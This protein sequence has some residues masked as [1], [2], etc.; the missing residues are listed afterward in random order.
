MKLFWRL[1]KNPVEDSTMP[2]LLDFSNGNHELSTASFSTYA[3]GGFGDGALGFKEPP[4]ALVRDAA[5]RWLGQ[6]VRATDAQ[7]RVAYEGLVAEVK[8]GTGHHAYA[9]GL[10][11]F[12]NYVYSEFDWAGSYAGFGKCTKGEVCRGRQLAIESDVDTAGQTVTLLGIKEYWQDVGSGPITPTLGLEASQ[13]RLRERLKKRSL[14]TDMGTSRPNSIE[15]TLW[16]WYSTLKFRK[17]GKGYNAYTDIATVIAGGMSTGN[18]AQYID[19]TDL[20]NM[21]AV[22]KTIVYNSSNDVMWLQDWIQGAIVGGDAA[23]RVLFFQIWEDRKPWLFSRPTAPR[24]FTRADSDKLFDASR[25][26]IP[27][28]LVRAGAYIVAESAESSLDDYSDVLDRP[29]RGLVQRTDY[30]D[31]RESLRVPSDSGVLVTDEILLARAHR[32]LRSKR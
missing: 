19:Q 16:G 4:S 26:P 28:Y 24:Y 17:T 5:A 27:P 32:R 29:Y 2:L 25:N 6:V 23:G 20:T 14:D 10:D 11:E 13:V 8:A 3:Q 1:H 18:K 15:L 12:A 30:D 31:V 7:G 22:G 21:P 9:R